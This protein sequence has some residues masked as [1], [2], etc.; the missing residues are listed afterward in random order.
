VRHRMLTVSLLGLV[1]LSQ[2]DEIKALVV[3][4]HNG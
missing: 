4:R 2:E 1:G 3:A